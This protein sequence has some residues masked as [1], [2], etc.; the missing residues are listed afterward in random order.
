MKAI[1][2][3]GKTSSPTKVNLHFT[4]DG[5]NI[6]DSYLLDHIAFIP[7]TDL[8]RSQNLRKNL[9]TYFLGEKTP[10]PVIQVENKDFESEIRRRYPSS[11]IL[12]DINDKAVHLSNRV[13][14]YFF[15]GLIFL[16]SLF[17]FVLY[18]LAINIGV[19]K[20]PVSFEKELGQGTYKS[21][22]L[23]FQKDTTTSKLLDEF[24]TELNRDTTYD[25]KFTAVHSK[26]TNA[27]ALPGGNIV[28]FNGIIKTMN[29]KSE[30]M[31]LMGHESGH[32]NLRHSSKLLVRSLAN[33]VFFS[34]II[35]DYGGVIAAAGIIAPELDKLKYGRA[36][37][38]EADE[39]G[40]E[41]L[42]NN[43]ET[44]LGMIN[45]FQSLEAE[46]EEVKELASK[47]PTFLQ[48]HPQI[49]ERIKEVRLKADEEKWIVKKND[50]L[51]KLFLKIKANIEFE[52]CVDKEDY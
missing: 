52:E 47:V 2:F 50:K 25:I 13:T 43:H 40:F 34:L 18:P 21:L 20:M 14:L 27:F 33:Y 5:F 17:Y 12:K 1:F 4:K 8:K 30:L 38:S 49:S 28:I 7:Y 22:M 23:E 15:G 6:Y 41:F 45:L 35:G 51:E 44:S 24:Y 42:K 36:L 11:P 32:V 29:D 37:E 19:N 10:S 31:A 46:Y 3:D 9:Y 39:Y 16:L 48:T 26:V